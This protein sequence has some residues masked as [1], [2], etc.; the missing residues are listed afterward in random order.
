[1]GHERGVPVS[2]RARQNPSITGQD[3]RSAVDFSLSAFFVCAEVRYNFAG[4]VGGGT[5]EV[6]GMTEE[7]Q[8]G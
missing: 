2:S 7:R 3:R 1:M 6:F 4:Y 5:S 8:G